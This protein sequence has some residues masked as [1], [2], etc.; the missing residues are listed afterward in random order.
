MITVLT[1]LCHTAGVE[2]GWGVITV[3][4]TVCHTVGGEGE[5][6]SPFGHCVSLPEVREG[7]DH[8][9]DQCVSH[10]RR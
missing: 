9:F 1:T 6:W 10:C 7:G 4:I 2:G 3:F 8:R 5:R